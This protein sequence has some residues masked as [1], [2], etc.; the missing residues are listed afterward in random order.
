MFRA[1]SSRTRPALAP[2]RAAPGSACTSQELSSSAT[3]GESGSRVRLG[4]ARRSSSR[5]RAPR[6]HP[7]GSIDHE[8]SKVLLLVH[9]DTAAARQSVQAVNLHRFTFSRTVRRCPED[10]AL[11][12]IRSL[13]L[14]TGR[15]SSAS[16]KRKDE[17]QC[18]P[19]E[20]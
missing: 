15:A 4:T 12:V 20:Q 3:E 1:Y 16:V 14:R 17:T 7:A 9:G 19:C 10:A 8:Q 2:N 5:F 11:D 13:T 18:C 6:R